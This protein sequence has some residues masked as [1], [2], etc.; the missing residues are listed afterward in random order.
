MHQ[1]IFNNFSSPFIKGVIGRTK[2]S[3]F[4]HSQDCEYD[5]IAMNILPYKWQE[6]LYR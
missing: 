1:N 4:P 5:I 6:E 2:K 3:P